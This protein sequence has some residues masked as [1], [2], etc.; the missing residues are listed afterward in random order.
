M[1]RPEFTRHDDGTVD[2][3]VTD[4]HGEE[5][6][7]RQDPLLDP[8]PRVLRLRPRLEPSPRPPAPAPDLSGFCSHCGWSGHAAEACSTCGAVGCARYPQRCSHQSSSVA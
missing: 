6:R 1:T 3:V 5:I 4:V 7:C 8:G 2:I